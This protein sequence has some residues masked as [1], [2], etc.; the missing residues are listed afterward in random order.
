MLL[1]TTNQSK[2]WSFSSLRKK[3]PNTEFMRSVFSRIWTEY[4]DL[5]RKSLYSVQMRENT[6]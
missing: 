3:F 5:L 1:P 2:L 4:R 6:D